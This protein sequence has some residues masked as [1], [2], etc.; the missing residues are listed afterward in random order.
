MRRKFGLSPLL[1][2]ALGWLAACNL[3]RAATP[4]PMQEILTLVASQVS[5]LSTGTALAI[6]STQT[7]APATVTP[8]FNQPT[9]TLTLIYIA[10]ATPTPNLL[11]CPL[12]I[13]LEDTRSGD[14]LH[15]RRCADDLQYDLGPLA[16]GTY[17]ASPN[18]AFLVYVTNDGMVYA[19]KIG[20]TRFVQII[21]L[22]KERYFTAINRK[23]VPRFSILFK[24]Q[25]PQ[26]QLILS[27][28]KFKQ[29]RAYFLPAALQE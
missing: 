18:Y 23:V 29:R 27:E 21:D 8:A 14:L 22:S 16:K 24:D 5:A 15:V 3:P 13:N 17:A 25:A 10:S 1:I 26:Y 20:E 4:D 9:P 7:A 28:Q 2:F 6:E 12:I 11:E 19:A